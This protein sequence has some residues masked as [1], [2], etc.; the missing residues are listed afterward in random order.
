[1]LPPGEH[2]SGTVTALQQ[3]ING[4]IFILIKSILTIKCSVY[5]TVFLIGP[6]ITLRRFC[7]LIGL[8]LKKIDLC[9][10]SFHYILYIKLLSSSVSLIYQ[11]IEIPINMS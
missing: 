2:E 8:P 5:F 4:F 3:M 7:K 1:M 9:G 11:S 10:T 6:E